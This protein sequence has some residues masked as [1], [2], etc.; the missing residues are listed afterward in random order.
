MKKRIFAFLC[1]AL[2]ITAVIPVAATYDGN[3]VLE[4]ADVFTEDEIAA[5]NDKAAGIY[6]ETGYNVCIL[7]TDSTGDTGLYEYLE[8]KYCEAAGTETGILLGVDLGEGKWSVY[9]SGEAEN[10]ITDDIEDTLWTAVGD[11]ETWYDG[12]AAYME[13]ARSYFQADYTEERTLSDSVIRLVDGADLL[14]YD[15]E[16]G[17]SAMLDEIS[18]R[19]GCDI[20]IVTTDTLNGK[21]AMEYADDYYDY[22]GFG[23]SGALLLVSTEDRD[24]Y[25]STAGECIAA[26]TDAGLEYMS[27]RFLSDLS[28]GRY[29]TAFSTFANS[30]AEFITQERSGKPYDINNVPEIPKSRT[31]P[32]KW[33]LYSLIAG[34]IVAFIVAQSMKSKLKT[35]HFQAAADYVREGSLNITQANEF[36]LYTHV[37]RT[38]RSDETSSVGGSS[39]HSSSSGSSHGG[40]GGKF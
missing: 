2:V 26:I 35:V 18:T 28:N 11:A 17:L 21:S 30:C 16:T 33:I 39:T 37:D 34:V 4:N 10:I 7:F 8:Q 3:Y 40:G 9:S 24:W 14:T 31:L 5:L 13:S 36:F 32:P 20:V 22:N 1:A 27:E 12:A 15:E 23:E 6:G 29:Y 25:V 19:L 38:A